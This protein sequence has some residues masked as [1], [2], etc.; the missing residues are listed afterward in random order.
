VQFQDLCRTIRL[1]TLGTVSLVVAIS[2]TWLVAAPPQIT[3]FMPLAVRPGDSIEFTIFGQNLLDA[4]NVWT[5]FASRCELLPA[6][7]EAAQ[8]GEK[9]VCR[10][11]I[12]RDEQVGI[13]A[14]RVV[15][16]EGVSNPVL[17]MLDDLQSIAESS[18][19][20]AP[21]QAQKINW[22]AAI[23]GQCDGVQEDFFRFQF[24]AG[25]R[26]SFE[27]VS[28]RLGSKLD[29]LL[30]LL[31]ADGAELLHLDDTEGTGG[32]SRF[33]HTFE[34]GGEYILA[35]RDV[36]YA[37]GGEF[38][39][40]LRI[41]SFPLIT[42]VYPA[43]GASGSVMSLELAGHDLGG[44]SK[45]HVAISNTTGSPRLTTFSV[46]T[47]PDMGSGWFQV[48]ANPGSESLE[49]EPNDSIADATTVSFPTA[50]NGRLEKPSDRDCFKF[51]AKKGQRV[52]CLAMTRELGSP[53]D[54]YMSLHK[55]DGSQIA[56]ARQDRRTVLAADIPEDGEYVLQVEDLL[57]GMGANHVYRIKL[58]DTFAGFSLHAEQMQYTSPH[59]GT[60]VA[61]IL[62]QRNGYNGPIELAVDGLGEGVKL[63]GNLFEGPERFLKITL[64]PSI[65]QG[66]IRHVSIVGRAKI[67][68][69]IVTV[70]ASQREPLNAMFPNVLSFPS[71][72]ENMIAV[73][74]GPPF[75]PFFDLSLA[76]T[77][78]YFP[79]LVGASTFDVNIARTSD[80]FKDPIALAV[81]GLPQ[82]VTASIAPVDDGS[83]AFRVSLAG[84]ADLAEG[85][86]PI[87]ILGTAK[88]QEQ[89]QTVKLDNVSLHI[90]KPLVVSLSM[91]GPIV[92]G[93]SQ[94]AEVNLQRFGDD[95]QPV[96]LQVSDGPA[97]LAAPIFVVIP[98]EASQMKI[99]FT[100]AADAP[101]GK[102][103][104][105]VAVASTA[106]KG[107]NITVQSKPA[108]IEIQPAPSQ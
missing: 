11:T 100:A 103:E 80:A 83:K 6:A 1:P 62:A 34:T 82:G 20:H 66:E 33:V 74:V 96:R 39:Y 61:K 47:A 91:L 28:Q 27:V 14:L 88:F 26:V 19:N 58:S 81:E 77:D 46:A 69:E 43:G 107:Q 22:P 44:M 35:L 23:D 108:T 75:P 7:D 24:A 4:R 50:L 105:L 60:F 40:R 25:Q 71:Q 64:P 5:S 30:R 16:G 21:S 70:A 76:S 42:S 67:G 87:R 101:A 89:T 45:L 36:R 37:G 54:L 95:P 2:A 15:T 18:D 79:Q 94:Q 41:G 38:R 59:A 17:V 65:A 90:T 56:V 63:E 31:T 49:T 52:Y 86:F 48:E 10:V 72:L 68:E 102:F 84:P 92:A 12:P 97:G 53:C 93:G 29:P 13:G 3:T 32:D 106:V 98:A 9:L 55:S 51:Q 78:V 73:G 99:P 104:N 8:K 85:S 57:V